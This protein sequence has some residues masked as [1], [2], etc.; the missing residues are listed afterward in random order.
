MSALAEYL[1]AANPNAPSDLAARAAAEIRSLIS[2]TDEGM[3]DVELLTR[4][5]GRLKRELSAHEEGV[6]GASRAALDTLGE[7]ARQRR[8]EGYDDLHDD[9]HDDFSLLKAALAYGEDALL[10]GTTG[11]SFTETAPPS[12]PWDEGDWKPKNLR[13]MLVI[14]GALVIAEMERLDRADEDRNRPR[15]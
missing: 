1:K 15:S 2:G 7:R 8:L 5:I 10:Q 13:R 12:W 3:Q 11:H 4:E 14:M 9:A 6:S